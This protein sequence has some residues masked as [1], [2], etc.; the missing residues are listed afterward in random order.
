MTTSRAEDVLYSSLTDIDALEQL[1]KIGLEEE[2]IPKPGMR[3]VVAWALD[4][5]FRTDQ[6]QAPSR[7][8]LFETWG[9]VIE[10]LEVE[11]EEADVEIDDI[12]WA[13]DSL[14]SQYI[15]WKFQQW[16]KESAQAIHEASMVDRLGALDTITHDLVTIALSLRDRT[17][18]VEGIEG[19]RQSLIDYKRRESE[20][21]L[22]RGMTFGVTEI[23]QYTY[24]L[25]EGELGV[26]AAGPKTGKSVAMAYILLNEWKQQRYT[27]LFTLENSVKMTYDRLVCMHL[28]VDHD[29]YRR[30]LCS[31]EDI[32]RVEIFLRER[33]QELKELVRIIQPQ[34]GQRSVQWMTRHARTLGTQSLLI[35]QLTFMEASHRSLK[36]PD[37]IADIMHDLKSE[38]SSG[39]NQVPCM[40]AH[41]INRE[42]M[43]EAKKNGFLEMYMLAEGSEVERTADLVVGLYASPDERKAQII[44]WQTLAFRRQEPKHWRVAWRP[45]IGQ[46]DALD[47]IEATA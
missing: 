4:Y 6:K 39:R 21:L 17:Q 2:C 16:Q 38:I 42:G 18:E 19:F 3:P 32:E 31:P 13:I 28:A 1:A 24:G 27:T 44:K 46:V 10:D 41:Q 15:L 43:R 47:E 40:I 11:I 22:F 29:L 26:L 12:G 8:A 37:K 14:K 45:W 5:F 34:K 35:D 9:Q 33:G 36:G 25:H 7:E 23:D 30:G 20:S